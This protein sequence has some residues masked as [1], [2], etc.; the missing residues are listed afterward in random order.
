[1]T[2][3]NPLI[4]E[5][6]AKL[7]VLAASQL[8]ETNA[9]SA[10]TKSP[11]SLHEELMK[12]LE[13]MP[14]A[15]RN[16]LF[17]ECCT[18][19]QLELDS[20][21]IAVQQKGM[22]PVELKEHHIQLVRLKREKFDGLIEKTGTSAPDQDK[23]SLSS[24]A[25][26]S[27]FITYCFR[28]KK[29]CYP[30]HTLMKLLADMDAAIGRWR[31]THITFQHQLLGLEMAQPVPEDRVFH[32][33]RFL[34]TLIIPREA[35][36]KNPALTMTGSSAM[37]MWKK[38]KGGSGGEGAGG[39]GGAFGAFGGGGNKPATAAFGGAFG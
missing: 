3:R 24:K 18:L 30:A 5:V 33:I 29:Q 25:V 36:P 7:G 16:D 39:A 12:W 11:S 34:A 27:A 20:D 21:N 4:V 17:N 19:A 35:L 2:M 13:S 32:E 9:W 37:A 14:L 31:E 6:E 15:K 23:P 38:K 22:I 1:M 10:G 26:K 8:E 28:H